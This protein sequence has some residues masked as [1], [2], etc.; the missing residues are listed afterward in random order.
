MPPV[1]IVLVESSRHHLRLLRALIVRQELTVAT[2][3]RTADN[4]L[5]A[6]RARRQHQPVV[7]ALGVL[8]A[9]LDPL[10]ALIVRQARTAM[11]RQRP[12]PAAQ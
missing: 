12:A 11:M 4:V 6:I 3:Q 10:R 5:P 9:A 7:H 8:I 1:L 2:R